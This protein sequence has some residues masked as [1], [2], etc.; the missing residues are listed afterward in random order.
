MASA[1]P[2]L[3]LPAPDVDRAEDP[4]PLIR[5]GLIAVA[6]LVASL[7]VWLAL[8]PLGGAAIAPGVIRST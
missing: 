1:L 4:R 5:A 6:L 8:A 7:G 3:L 2:D